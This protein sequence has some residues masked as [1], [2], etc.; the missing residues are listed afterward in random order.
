M[1]GLIFCLLQRFVEEDLDSLFRGMVYT[2]AER[3][4]SIMV[5]DVTGNE[6]VF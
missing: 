3:E 6:S 4:D 5:P 1:H 2:T